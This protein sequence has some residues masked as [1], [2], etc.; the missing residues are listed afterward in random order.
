MWQLSGSDRCCCIC[1][2]YRTCARCF[3]LVGTAEGSIVFTRW[4]QYAHPTNMLFLESAW[5]S[6]LNSVSIGLAIFVLPTYWPRCPQ[7]VITCRE[8]C[9]S[10][11]PL[12][13]DCSIIYLQASKSIRKSTIIHSIWTILQYSRSIY[14]DYKNLHYKRSNCYQ[15]KIDI[16]GDQSPPTN[17]HCK[18]SISY[19]AKRFLLITG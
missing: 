16:I 8:T 4:R 11:S 10:P 14:S 7:E 12:C 9:F 15:C 1:M 3:L 5:I 19:N 13:R 18:R 17:L 2:C 6:P